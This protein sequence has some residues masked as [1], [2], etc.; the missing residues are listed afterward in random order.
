MTNHKSKGGM[1][2][3]LAATAMAAAGAYILYGSK[4]APKNRS[5]MKGWAVKAKGEVMQ[6]MEAL[7]EMD[8]DTYHNVIDSITNRY[9]A[10]DQKEVKALVTEL[11]S[12][13]KN[14]QKEI[15]A[16]KKTVAKTVSKTVK[17]VKNPPVK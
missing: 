3:L 11:K 17:K 6:K 13:W 15:G 1:G 12:H 8:E 4:N 10:V 14:I 2:K 7:K 16:S 5:V 9:K